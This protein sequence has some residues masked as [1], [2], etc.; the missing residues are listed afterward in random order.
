M[1][2]VARPAR[3][4]AAS[5]LLSTMI[6][7]ASDPG[8]EVQ[9][10]THL[11]LYVPLPVEVPPFVERLPGPASSCGV[12]SSTAGHHERS[13]ARHRDHAASVGHVARPSRGDTS[14]VGNEFRWG[15]AE[16]ETNDVPVQDLSTLRPHSRHPGIVVAARAVRD[17][18]APCVADVSRL[19]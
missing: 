3:E 18:V 8:A 16:I 2:S 5:P 1:T 14:R 11:T 19:R 6:V 10:T 15:A 13:R 4:S 12:R 17:T 7:P 9:L